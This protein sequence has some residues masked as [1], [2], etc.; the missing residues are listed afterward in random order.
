[1]KTTLG[2]SLLN[3]SPRIRALR[4][5]R[6]LINSGQLPP[7][8]RLPAEQ[9]LAE[10]VGVSRPTLRRAIQQLQAEG[11]IETGGSQGRQVVSTRRGQKAESIISRSIVVLTD[12]VVD[13]TP[14]PLN[15]TLPPTGGIQ[16]WIHTG[17]IQG[18]HDAG[19]NEIAIHIDRLADGFEYLV[20]EHP[21]GVIAL[22]SVA[23]SQAG[24]AALN[25]LQNSG[26]PV[27]VYGPAS[28][29]PVFDT[30]ESDHESGCYALTRWLIGQKRSRI[31]RY[32]HL[33]GD[34]AVSDPP[35]AWLQDRDA[36]YLRAISEAGLTTL[37]PIHVFDNRPAPPQVNRSTFDVYVRTC[38]GFLLEHLSG[39]QPAD[40][41]L[42]SSDGF[43]LACAAAIRL[44]GKRP[45]EDVLLAGYDNYWAEMPERQWESTVPM[46]TVDKQNALMGRRLVDLILDRA[47]K[48]APQERVHVRVEPH[49]VQTTPASGE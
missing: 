11:L 30:V 18:S 6:Q 47:E 8:E 39:P 24:I 20:D 4:D 35:P 37:P 36:G 34:T 48:R 2:Q 29:F 26:V 9:M 19:L 22:G 17:V 21:Y 49:L 7:G 15:P 40:A 28:R 42:C 1:V 32:W 41:I 44:L 5:L 46:A 31:L 27:A 43:V 38:V 45:N 10:R 14:T 3:T 16:P 33:H 25:A 13:L 23:Q 12:A